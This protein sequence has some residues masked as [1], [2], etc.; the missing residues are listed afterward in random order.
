MPL[1]EQLQTVLLH[2]IMHLYIISI[3]Y[4]TG[5]SKCWNSV[6]FYYPI[7]PMEEEFSKIKAY[8][9]ASGAAIQAVLNGLVISKTPYHNSSNCAVENGLQYRLHQKRADSI[10]YS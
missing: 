10:H 9:E 2:W 4:S 8:L 5:Y 7:Y 6:H 1:M 3:T